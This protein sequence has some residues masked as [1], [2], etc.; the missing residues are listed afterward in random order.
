MLSRYAEQDN[1]LGLWD[2]I[3][4]A[5]LF[6]DGQTKPWAAQKAAI[7]EDRGYYDDEDMQKRRERMVKHWVSAFRYSDS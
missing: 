7:L 1:Y 2:E 3:L 6:Q 4:T 5:N